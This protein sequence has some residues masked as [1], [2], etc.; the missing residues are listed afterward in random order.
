M[1]QLHNSTADRGGGGGDHHDFMTY[2][3]MLG[4]MRISTPVLVELTYFNS[5]I[6]QF[7]LFVYKAHISTTE[8][9]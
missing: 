5:N 1:Y 9:T 8:L 3:E 2:C 7:F 6:F 4:R